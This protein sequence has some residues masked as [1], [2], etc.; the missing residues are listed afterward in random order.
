MLLKN[1]VKTRNT[2]SFSHRAI[3]PFIMNWLYSKCIKGTIN[4]PNI[5]VTTRRQQEKFTESSSENMSTRRK[6][7]TDIV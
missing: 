4:G 5:K 3:W 6:K 7:E 1:G 2:K